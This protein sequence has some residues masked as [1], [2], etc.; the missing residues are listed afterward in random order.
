MRDLRTLRCDLRRYV[1]SRDAA[2]VSSTPQ[3]QHNALMWASIV[4]LVVIIW[5]I[6]PIGIGILLGTFLAFMAEPI[7][8]RLEH[9][10]GRRWGSVASPPSCSA[11]WSIAPRRSAWRKRRRWVRRVF[12]AC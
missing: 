4:A 1:F 2:R 7:F 3:S 6:L 9:R 12:P 10:I 11:T 8:E 5:I